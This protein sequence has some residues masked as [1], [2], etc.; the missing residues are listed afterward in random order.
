VKR[1]A[2][3]LTFIAIVAIAAT[4]QSLPIAD[5]V[6]NAGEYA[7]ERN[8]SG[9]RTLFT[10]SPDGSTIYA[11]VEAKSSGWVAL[12]F[13]SRKMDGAHM[14]FGY[15]KDGAAVHAEQLGK[16]WTHSATTPFSLAKAVVERDG[17][18]VLEVAVPAARFLKGRTL[19]TLAATGNKDDFVTRH[20][21]RLSQ[22]VD[23]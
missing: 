18:T 1:S 8:A 16:G 10:L 2:S 13:G 23:F 15:V 4:A 3:I 9:I 12:A 21:A 6:I 5:G 11:A 14:I 7:I 22:Q 20:S 19:D 17:M